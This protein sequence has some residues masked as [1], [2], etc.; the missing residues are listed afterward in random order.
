MVIGGEQI[1][2]QIFP[3]ADRLLLS[4][5]DL[6]IEG[7]DAFFPEFDLADWTEVRRKTLRGKDPK[8]VLIEYIRQETD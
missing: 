1:F 5:V 4:Y 3:V 7:T 2:R 6:K 8:C